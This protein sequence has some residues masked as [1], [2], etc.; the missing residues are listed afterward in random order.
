MTEEA[1]DKPASSSGSVEELQDRIQRLK[2]DEPKA[3][4]PIASIHLAFSL[5]ATVIGAL[6]MGDFFGRKLAEYA[7]NPQ[8]RLVGWALGLGLAG[9]AGYKLLKPYIV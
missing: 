7:G 9:L 8:Y 6:L 2:G 3:E 4:A 1:D 5:G